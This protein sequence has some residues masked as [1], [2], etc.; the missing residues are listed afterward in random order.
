MI[1]TDKEIDENPIY[2]QCMEEINDLY[3]KFGCP[4]IPSSGPTT[5]DSIFLPFDSED[6]DCMDA[7]EKANEQY[8]F[9][10]DKINRGEHPFYYE[11][12]EWTEFADTAE[13]IIEQHTATD[14]HD[15][16]IRWYC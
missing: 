1:Y 6:E 4:E 9:V 5:D 12:N 3:E 13:R 16:F 2:S 14:A 10:L 8:L 11:N 15:L 7:V